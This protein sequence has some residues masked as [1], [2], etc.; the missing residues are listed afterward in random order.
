M[1]K[2]SEIGI[3][4]NK[5]IKEQKIF[6]IILPKGNLVWITINLKDK[7]NNLIICANI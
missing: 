6:K 1:K 5:Y 2:K 7:K 4:I 3:I